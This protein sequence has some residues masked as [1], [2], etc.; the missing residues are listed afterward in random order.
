MVKSLLQCPPQYHKPSL[1]A[2]AYLLTVHTGRLDA[3]TW[4]RTSSVLLMGGL[5]FGFSKLVLAVVI[6][7]LVKSGSDGVEQAGFAVSVTS[8]EVVQSATYVLIMAKM[9]V[10]QGRSQ[11]LSPL[12]AVCPCATLAALFARL[13]GSV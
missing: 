7:N 2:E 9:K 12:V 13:L 11:V 1:Y 10:P 3:N 8:R 4:S 5:L 6:L